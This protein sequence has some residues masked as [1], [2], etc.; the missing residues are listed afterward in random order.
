[1]RKTTEEE[2][3]VPDGVRPS[4]EVNSNTKVMLSTNFRKNQH[5]LSLY[6]YEPAH[7]KTTIRPV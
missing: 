7:D 4:S 5:P 2:I 3:I 6:I 1:M